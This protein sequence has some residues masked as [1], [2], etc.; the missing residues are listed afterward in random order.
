L[1]NHKA[2]RCLARNFARLVAIWPLDQRQEITVLSNL[3]QTGGFSRLC[4]SDLKQPNCAELQLIQR[5][6]LWLDKSYDSMG[7]L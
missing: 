4:D 3:H 7:D 2:N 5:I 1:R 6:G